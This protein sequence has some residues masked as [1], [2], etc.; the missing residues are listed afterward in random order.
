MSEN[1]EDKPVEEGKTET[2]VDEAN[3]AAERME[4]ANKE[5]KEILERQEALAAHKALAGK[6]EA[7]QEPKKDI[8]AEEKKVNAAAEYFEGTQLETDIRKANEKK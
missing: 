4:A 3:K 7:G 8:S 6:S 2:L 5:S 1:E